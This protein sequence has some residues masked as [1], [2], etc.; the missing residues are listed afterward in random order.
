MPK[1][2]AH[3]RDCEQIMRECHVYDLIDEFDNL[4]SSKRE[5]R[6][7]TYLSQFRHAAQTQSRTR[8]D[9]QSVRQ[10]V[11]EYLRKVV[12]TYIQEYDKVDRA[13]D[14]NRWRKQLIH[15]I[16]CT[17]LKSQLT[18]E[19]VRAYPWMSDLIDNL[20]ACK[21]ATI[22]AAEIGR[23]FNTLKRES[24]LTKTTPFFKLV[25]Q[26]HLTATV[27]RTQVQSKIEM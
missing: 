6:D 14:I 26:Y 3:H 19:I 18:S 8:T 1:E 4:N 24:D 16:S 27:E 22:F 25:E 21:D 23:I 12:D 15:L 10:M 9:S 5:L 7:A 17:K 2:L 13:Y 11:L 20:A